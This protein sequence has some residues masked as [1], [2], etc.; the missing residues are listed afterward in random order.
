MPSPSTPA[1]DLAFVVRTMARTAVDNERAFSDLDAVAG[2]GDFGY[3]LARGFEIVLADWDTLAAEA[4]AEL[5]KKVALVIS[6]RVGGTSGPLWGTA[7]LRAST[8]VKDR[9]EPNAA[10]AVAMLRAAAEGIKARG[11]SDLGDKT[12]LDALIPMTDAL[13]QRLAG[14]EPDAGGAELAALAA[15]TAR[16]AADATQSMQARRGRQSYTG[17][18]SIGSPDPGAVAVAVM[19]ERVAAEWDARD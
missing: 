1:G 6:K 9:P 13:E 10:D 14:G 11:K 8:A 12:L 3:S 19:A 15:T 2:D 17:E 18:R 7:F 16:A 4:P 5:L